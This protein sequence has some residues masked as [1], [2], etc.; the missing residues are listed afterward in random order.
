MSSKQVSFGILSTANIGSKT[1]KAIHEAKL[2]K[3]ICVASREMEKAKEFAQEHDIPNYYDSY[4]QVLDDDQV[5]AVY[6]PLPSTM[7]REW[8]IKAAEKR[9]HVLVEKPFIS[10]SEVRDI[11]E[12]CHKNVRNKIC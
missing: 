8:A 3:V 11:I 7:K 5:D 2:G 10:E 1:V 12:A 6:I 4:E 9:K